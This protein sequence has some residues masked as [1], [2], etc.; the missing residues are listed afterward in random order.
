MG[1]AAPAFAVLVWPFAGGACAAGPHLWLV[2][3]GLLP[4]AWLV[5]RSWMAVPIS[6]YGPLETL[7][8][9]WYFL[10]RAGYAEVDV[11]PGAGWLDRLKFLQFVVL[12]VG[13]QFAVAGALLGLVGVVVQG[14]RS[15][16]GSPPSSSPPSSCRR[17]C[18]S[19]CSASATTR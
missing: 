11:H 5:Y 10:S 15:A 6:F 13:R 4:Y 14:E 3:A 1:L 2:L 12:E 16:P 9:V 19:C 7:T 8:E 18:C 17:S